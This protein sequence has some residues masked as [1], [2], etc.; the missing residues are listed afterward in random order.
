MST[1]SN[2]LLKY[3]IGSI[4]IIAD[5]ALFYVGKPSEGMSIVAIGL[6]IL[7]V[8]AIGYTYGYSKGFR[9]ACRLYNK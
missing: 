6:G 5:A 9:K 1:E 3:L 7:G 4:L 8:G 2:V